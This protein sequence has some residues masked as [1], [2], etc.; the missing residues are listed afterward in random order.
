MKAKTIKVNIHEAKTQFS[1]YLKKAENGQTIIVCRR[2]VPIAEIRATP[3]IPVVDRKKWFGM[4]KGKVVS[5]RSFSTRC[6][7]IF[8]RTSTAVSETATRYMHIP[9]VHLRIGSVITNRPDGFGGSGR[10][11]VIERG[12]G[13]GDCR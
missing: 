13:L 4:D 9:L 12:F 11:T 2:N 5:S 7:A 8:W 1:K 6:L 10:R 3:V